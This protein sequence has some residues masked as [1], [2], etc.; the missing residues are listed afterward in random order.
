MDLIKKISQGLK[1]F[2]MTYFV[3]KGSLYVNNI[4]ETLLYSHL[5]LR[6]IF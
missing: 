1:C 3:D 5:V 4:L 2:I 6:A